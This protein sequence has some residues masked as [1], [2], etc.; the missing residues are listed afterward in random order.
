M[1]ATPTPTPTATPTPAATPA[2]GH[3]AFNTG[4]VY[5]RPSVAAKAFA[6]AWRARLVSAER[7]AWLDDQL[8]FNELVWHGYRNHADRAIRAGRP[9]GKV[10]RLCVHGS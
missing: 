3:A 6:A 2:A 9:D 5:F 4:V 1:R 7:S 8:A 10:R